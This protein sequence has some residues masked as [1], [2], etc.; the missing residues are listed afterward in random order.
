MTPRTRGP[1]GAGGDVDEGEGV[2]GVGDDQ[3]IEQVRRLPAAGAVPL[4]RP[5]AGG[6]AVHARSRSASAGPLGLR[7][8]VLL[9]TAVRL[10]WLAVL[11]RHTL[12]GLLRVAVGSRSCEG[13]RL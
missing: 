2:H 11:L 4:R 1:D 13:C 5:P 6:H 10:L 9:G 7:V 12:R 3:D 8:G